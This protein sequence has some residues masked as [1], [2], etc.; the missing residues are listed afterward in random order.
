M[1]A[2]INEPVE[3]LGIRIGEH[4]FHFGVGTTEYCVVHPENDCLDELSLE[5]H[6]VPEAV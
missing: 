1:K 4:V 2:T 6:E 5:E 3:A